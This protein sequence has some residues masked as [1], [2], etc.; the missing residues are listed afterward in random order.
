V[1]YPLN[2]EQKIG[3]QQIRKIIHSYCLCELGKT[4]AN[5]ISFEVNY[6]KLKESLLRT[7]DLK[8]ILQIEEYFPAD[9]YLDKTDLLERIKIEGQYAELEDIVEF[10]KVLGAFK[11]LF[12][13]FRQ[14]KIKTKYQHLHGFCS[15]I[16]YF[17]FLADR[18]DH[19]LNS[20]GK[21]KDGATPELKLIRQQLRSK[22]NEINAKIQRIHK[23]VIKEGIVEEGTSISVRNGRPVIPVTAGNKKRIQGIIHDESASGKTVFIEPSS[24][25]EL[26]NEFKELQYAEAREIKKILISL[27]N[28]IRPFIAELKQNFDLLGEIDLIRAKARFAQEID[29]RLPMVTEAQVLNWRD[30]RHPLLLLQFKSENKSVV[31]LNIQLHSDSRILVISGPNAGGKSVCLKTVG[32]VQYMFQCGLLPP[33]TENSEM[34]MFKDIFIDIGDE[35]SIENDLSTY[36]SHLVAMKHFLKNSNSQSLILID[37]FGTGTEP[38]LGGAIAESVLSELNRKE[39][40]GVIT[41]HYANL[42]HFASKTNGIANGAMMFDMNKLEPTYQLSMGKPGSS[43]AFE[44]ARK[45]GLSEHILKDAEEKIGKDHVDFDKNLRKILRDKKYWEDKRQSVR[46]NEKR[47]SEILSRYEE[48]LKKVEETKKQIVKEAKLEA[49][50]IVDSANKKIENAIKE[51]KEA[52]AEKEK[53]KKIR[54]SLSDFGSELQGEEKNDK[55]NKKIEKIKE[56][57]QKLSKRRPDLAQTNKDSNIKEK[58]ESIEVGDYVQMKGQDTFGEVLEA[59]GKSLMVAFGNLITTIDRNKL[60]KSS[61]NKAKQASR[62]T[63][64]AANS[65]NVSKRKLSFKPNLDIRGKR[66]EEAMRMVGE[67]IDEAVMVGTTDLRI[68]HGKGNGILREV[69][70]DYLS[71]VDVVGKYQDEQVDM[72]GSGIT[73][74]KLQF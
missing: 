19:I 18:I 69:I 9:N 7:N 4:K 30:A 62:N 45:I 23:E 29:G 59:N 14:E 10:R 67:F 43:F 11:T 66:A 55:Y 36:S 64:G 2:F 37:E 73:V 48:E 34:G 32:L 52:Q 56:R 65:I 28:D 5:A 74:V 15:N 49:Q 17:P 53:T 25:V 20:N 68:L 47:L 16:Q 70:R 39:T 72:G 60:I 8:T 54:E 50:G 27:A 63:S 40:V 26:N 13:Y 31:P 41:T 22:E 57:K 61:K 21:I 51:I 46:I 42:K 6:A 1:F 35:Q 71:T 58:A 12:Q 33:L 38:V 44:I 3:F 24:V